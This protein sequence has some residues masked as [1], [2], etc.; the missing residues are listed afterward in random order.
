[1]GVLMAVGGCSWG[2]SS[3]RGG[4]ACLELEGISQ[5]SHPALAG[6]STFINA[7]GIWLLSICLP[8]CCRDYGRKRSKALGSGL[9]EAAPWLAGSA[10]LQ[11]CPFPQEQGAPSGCPGQKRWEPR[12][13]G[14]KQ[15]GRCAG[16]TQGSRGGCHRVCLVFLTC[17]PCLGMSSRRKR[18]LQGSWEH[19]LD[20]RSTVQSLF[21]V[22]NHQQTRLCT[23]G[24]VNLRR[25]TLGLG[26][27][28]VQT[29]CV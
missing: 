27:L 26:L 4:R 9:A 15:L 5:I 18:M 29:S 14:W 23:C 10:G 20:G 1:M 6:E 12:A 13:C 3:I 25:Q 16:L 22:C 11:P 28:F 19:S 24:A 8:L 2:S 17:L 7:A 21:H